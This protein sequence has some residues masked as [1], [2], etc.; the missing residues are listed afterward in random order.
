MTLLVIEV[1]VPHALRDR[2]LVEEA[3]SEDERETMLRASWTSIVLG[4][5]AFAAGMV[6]PLLAPFALAIGA[7]IVGRLVR[8]RGVTA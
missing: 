2:H 8:R 7:P 6:M 5:I 3:V 1:K 4:V